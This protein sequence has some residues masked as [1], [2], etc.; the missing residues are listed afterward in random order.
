MSQRIRRPRNTGSFTTDTNGRLRCCKTRVDQAVGGVYRSQPDVRRESVCGG[1]LDHR[2]DRS[3]VQS[4]VGLYE[5]VTSLRPLLRRG[6][7]QANRS[8]R[9]GREVV[10]ALSQR[11]DL[12]ATGALEPR[13]RACRNADAGLLRV[14][15]RRVRVGAPSERHAREVVG[16][17]RTDASPRLAVADKASSPR[18]TACAVEHAMAGTCL[19]RY[20]RREPA[21]RSKAHSASARYS[22]S[23]PVPELRTAARP[24]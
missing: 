22:L 7:G 16:A 12:E 6:M 18:P 15:G 3:H 23:H 10:Q 21:L 24:G 2:M 14:D 19:A 1:T 9:L 17:D 5:G 20:H 8:R 4:L 13:C 11:V